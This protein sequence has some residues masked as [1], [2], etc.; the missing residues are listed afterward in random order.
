MSQFDPTPETLK[1]AGRDMYE[2]L[3]LAKD[4]LNWDH[5]STFQAILDA[6]AKAEGRYGDIS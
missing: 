2:A 3:R 5:G 1:A 6:I 4:A